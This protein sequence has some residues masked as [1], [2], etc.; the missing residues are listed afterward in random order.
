V[1]VYPH[2]PEAFTQ[3]LIW[4]DG[5]LYE[6]TGLEGRSSLRRVKLETGE[7][8]QKV[9]VAPELFAEGL[10]EWKHHLLQLTWTSQVGFI[11]DLRSFSNLGRFRYSGEGWGLTHD[12]QSLILSDGSSILRF[13]NP[14]DFRVTRKLQVKDSGKP[15]T[16][17]NELEWIR[18]EVWA[19]VWQTSLIA[20]ISPVDGR[21]LRW[22][23]LDGLLPLEDRER[24]ADVLNGIAYDEQHDRVF[25]TGKRWP[26][27]F[28][29]RVLQSR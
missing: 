4:R 7:V 16:S 5:F 23:D 24:G 11:Y 8:L 26:K 17:L 3:G 2:D 9:D 15:V 28:E 12:G 20:C 29:I 22:I 10:T 13:L 6:S 21:V 27:L 19:N 14:N 1:N 25:V 18:G